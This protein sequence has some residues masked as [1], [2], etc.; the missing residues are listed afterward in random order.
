[1]NELTELELVKSRSASELL[2][3]Q[4]AIVDSGGIPEN[5]VRPRVL[6]ITTLSG[7][8]ALSIL[9]FLS[10]LLEEVARRRQ[11][12]VIRGS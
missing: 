3:Q 12:Q 10:F 2:V 1:M 4:I 6:L 7:A 5:P 11:S 9:I 8:V